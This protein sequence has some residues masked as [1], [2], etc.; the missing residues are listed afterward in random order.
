[1]NNEKMNNQIDDYT[2]KGQ[3][4]IGKAEDKATE[5]LSKANN[6]AHDVVNKGSDLTQDMEDMLKKKII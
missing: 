4:Y 6:T 3:E 1:M 5:L 2:K